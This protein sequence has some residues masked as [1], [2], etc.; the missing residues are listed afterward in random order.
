MRISAFALAAAAAWLVAAP[1]AGQDTDVGGNV[2][3]LLSL[4]LAEPDGLASFPPG[5]GEHELAIRARVTSTE[6]VTRVSAADGDASSGRRLG[7]LEGVASPLEARAGAGPF[8][9]LGAAV[10]PPLA[11]FRR[12]LA[13]SLVT[14]A[15]R[16]RVGAGERPRGAKTILVTVSPDAP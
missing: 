11:V 5:P 16:Q 13:N 14:I 4:A 10:E 7:R 8:L 9:S 12:P 3:S 2:P 1:A 15:L 6:R